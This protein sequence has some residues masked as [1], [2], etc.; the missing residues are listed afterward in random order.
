MLE[1]DNEAV[2]EALIGRGDFRCID[3][4]PGSLL[5]HHGEEGQVVFVQQDG[6]A[7]EALELERAA[8]VVNVGVGDEDLLELEAEGVETAG[9][10]VDLVAGVDDD[11]LA[12]FLIAQ[13]GAV[14]FQRA[15]GE[16]LDDHEAI[17]V[18]LRNAKGQTRRAC[19]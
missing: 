14:A 3:A 12:G 9:D 13:D 18:L 17:V 8:N 6:S 4:E 5:V 1:A 7:G 10:A 16:G 19:L 2:G 15:D 11:G